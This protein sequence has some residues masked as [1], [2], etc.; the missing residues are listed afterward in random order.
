MQEFIEF[1]SRLEN[2]LQKMIADRE[3]IRLEFLKE[4]SV[5]RA[6]TWLQ[7]LEIGNLK[8]DG[9]LFLSFFWQRGKHMRP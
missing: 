1:Q 2:S 5:S 3:M 9:N 6:I 4:D 8:Y 7:E